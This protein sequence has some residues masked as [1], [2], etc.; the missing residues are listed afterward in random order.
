M[1]RVMIFLDAEYVVQRMK[2]MRGS[3][4][5]VGRRDIEWAAIIKWITGIRKLQRCYYYSAEFSKEE[6]ERTFQEQRE[7]LKALKSSIPHFEIK[8]GRLVRVGR[9]WMQKGLDVKIA[10]DMFSKAA[11]NHYDAAVLVS[12]DSDFAEVI[13]EVKERYGK[14]VELF[15]FDRTVH[16]ALLL[17]PDKHVVIDPETC[18]KFR[19]WKD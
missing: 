14:H 16:D 11:N 5:I 10:V 17:A 15:T 7:H 12:G 19:F 4:R 1:D 3:R 8:L 2:D 6:N 9:E 18:R 13:T